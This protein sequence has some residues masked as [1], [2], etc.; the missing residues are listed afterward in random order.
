MA[1]QGRARTRPGFAAES[2]LGLTAVIKQIKAGASLDIF[3][4]ADVSTLPYSDSRQPNFVQADV[5]DTS[6]LAKPLC[7]LPTRMLSA[8]RGRRSK[9]KPHP[10]AL[11]L[12]GNYGESTCAGTASL[13]V[14]GD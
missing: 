1:E 7:E 12:A 9:Q 8:L 5:D 13:A 10:F 2:C 14:S 6:L 4:S 3:I 11:L